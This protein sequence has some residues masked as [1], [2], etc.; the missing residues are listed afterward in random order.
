MGENYRYKIGVV[1]SISTVA[2]NLARSS[3]GQ[4]YPAFNRGVVSSNLTGPTDKLIRS[5]MEVHWPSKPIGMS[6]T[7]I[8]STKDE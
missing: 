3:T 7:L 1:G 8:E 5:I 2:T 6:S 4:M